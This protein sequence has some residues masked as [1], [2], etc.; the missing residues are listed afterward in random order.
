MPTFGLRAPIAAALTLT[1]AGLA[2]APAATA[3][4]GPSDPATIAA[5][6]QASAAAANQA[7]IDEDWDG[8]IANADTFDANHGDL[9]AQFDA[10]T[11]ELKALNKASKAQAG[12]LADA[13]ADAEAKRVAKSALKNDWAATKELL[14]Q[15][16]IDLAAAKLRNQTAGDELERV[17]PAYEAADAAYSA[18]V[19][20][21]IAGKWTLWAFVFDGDNTTTVRELAGANDE[22]KQKAEDLRAESDR[23]REI[24]EGSDGNGGKKAEYS[25]ARTAYYGTPA[26]WKTSGYCIYFQVDSC[27]TAAGVDAANALAALKQE[28]DSASAAYRDAD[29]T[30][31]EAE[32]WSY[33]VGLAYGSD[34]IGVAGKKDAFDTA[35]GAY[36]AAYEEAAAGGEALDALQAEYDALVLAVP[37][38]WQLFVSARAVWQDAVAEAN[39]LQG[40]N[41]QLQLDIAAKKAQKKALNK[42]IK[43][44]SDAKQDVVDRRADLA[45]FHTVLEQT[46]VLLPGSE[47]V[48]RNAGVVTLPFSIT[49]S[50]LFDLSDATVEITAPLGLVADCDI[51][52]SGIVAAGATVDC[53]VNYT[54]PAA[55]LFSDS[56]LTITVVLSGYIPLGP[57]NPRA[58]AVS[59]TLV[60]VTSTTTIQI[61]AQTPVE[62]PGDEE[63][64]VDETTDAAPVVTDDVDAQADDAAAETDEA[65]EESEPAPAAVTTAA[66]PVAAS[67]DDATA[68]TTSAELSGTGPADAIGSL[69]DAAVLLLVGLGLVLV[70]RRRFVSGK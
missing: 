43:G 28:R 1:L 25:D 57:G 19:H 27:R 58:T 10:A 67:D 66:A 3:S 24:Y 30:A 61:A 47:N 59:R 53:V 12:P 56:E 54:V 34:L 38:K 4:T 6:A 55:D 33:F 64:V 37:A 46:K 23:L 62:V 16:E 68:V 42:L 69:S 65:T 17:T 60:S 35:K 21:V 50:Q 9:V 20:D 45:D 22:A 5:A 31:D 8:V 29:D 63:P 44:L 2:I 11:K 36:D 52:D 14:G 18:R 70:S 39:A 49:N 7:F 32:R 51:P 15:A 13:L 40:A 26:N 48:S 41:D